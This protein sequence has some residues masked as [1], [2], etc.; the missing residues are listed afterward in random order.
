MTPELRIERLERGVADLLS[1]VRDLPDEALYR[2]PTDGE[3][4]VMQNLAHVAEMLPYWAHQA[5]AI[6]HAPGQPFGRTHDDPVRIGEIDA[7]SNDVLEL[8][9]SRI[10]GAANECV[11]I[12]R[13]L[14]AEAWPKAGIHPSRGQM[15]VEQMIDTFVVGHVEAHLRQ[16]HDALDSVKA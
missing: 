14:P 5:E 7:H 3:W 15:T 8:T 9:L 2:E 6:D 12:L 13:A 1:T 4:S 10:Q 16:V 11:S